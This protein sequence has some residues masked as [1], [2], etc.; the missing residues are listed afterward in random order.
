MSL[1]EF[2]PVHELKSRGNST[3]VEILEV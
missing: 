2:N 1:M 3:L